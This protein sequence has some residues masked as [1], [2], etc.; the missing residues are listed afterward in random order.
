MSCIKEEQ[1]GNILDIGDYMPEF[2]V[3]LNDGSVLT[4]ADL[5]KGY[6]MP[7]SAQE[8]RAIYKLFATSRVPRV[9]VFKNWVIRK[10]YTDAPTPT[11]S[12]IMSDLD[13]L[14]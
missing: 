5:S 8:T 3:L 4:S 10:I 1:T 12:D 6:S 13:A 14:L 2:S 11:Y 9:Y 7:Y